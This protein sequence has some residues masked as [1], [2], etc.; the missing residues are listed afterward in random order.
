MALSDPQPIGSTN[1]DRLPLD[2]PEID[3]PEIDTLEPGPGNPTPRFRLAAALLFA[4]FV[5]TLLAGIQLQNDFLNNQPLFTFSQGILP[6]AWIAQ[7]PSRLLLGIPFSAT[8]LLILL[9]HEMGHYVACR[10]Y[11]V[12]ATLPYFIPFP[13]PIEIEKHISSRIVGPSRPR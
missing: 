12:Q 5:T 11:G 3:T 2:T 13:T 8:L 7:Q 6:L 9:S 10:R 4:T 1:G